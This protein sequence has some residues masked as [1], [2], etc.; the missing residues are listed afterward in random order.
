MQKFNHIFKTDSNK[1]SGFTLLELL[2]S[3][4]MVSMVTIIIAQALKL[5]INSWDRAQREGDTFQARVVI[6]S[7][8]R[9]QLDS[10][11][12]EKVFAQ[13]HAPLKLVFKG[14]EKGLSFFTSYTPMAGSLTGL[15]R[16]TYVHDKEKRILLLYQKLILTLEDVKDIYCPLSEMWDNQLE[17][18]G[19]IVGINLFNI[20]YSSEKSLSNNDSGSVT[21]IWE[22]KKNQY[23]GSVYLDFQTIGGGIASNQELWHFNVGT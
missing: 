9:K 5:S 21:N 23:P 17:P 1:D 12:R 16:V 15:L 19:K 2:V 11:V 22:D 14:T 10:I 3:M 7:L 18:S 6:P 20:R 4:L 8:L 13:G